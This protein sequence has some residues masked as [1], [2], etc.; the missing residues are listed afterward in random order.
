LQLMNPVN[1]MPVSVL[2][3][4]GNYA[5]KAYSISFDKTAYMYVPSRCS[6]GKGCSIHVALHGCRQ[7]KERVGETVALHAGYNE[8]AELNNIIVI[9]PQVKKSLVFPINPQGCFDW[10][11]YTNNNYANKL[12]PQMSAVK[13]IIDTVRAIHA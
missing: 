12:G 13:N 1:Y 5:A 9:Y 2:P 6:K 8:V 10:W 4:N 11:S 3:S 7:G